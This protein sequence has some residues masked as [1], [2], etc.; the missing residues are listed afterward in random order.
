MSALG[1]QNWT[2]NTTHKGR[3]SQSDILSSMFDRYGVLARHNHSFKR[4][5]TNRANSLS[6]MVEPT[7]PFLHDSD[8]IIG[9]SD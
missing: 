5:L 4:Q 3:W 2:E 9:K 1:T 6:L 8:L 7:M